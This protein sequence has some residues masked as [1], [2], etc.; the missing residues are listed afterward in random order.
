MALVVVDVGPR[1]ISHSIPSRKTMITAII[2]GTITRTELFRFIDRRSCSTRILAPGISSQACAYCSR[3][4][5]RPKQPARR[6]SSGAGHVGDT[7]ALWPSVQMRMKLFKCVL[8]HLV[9]I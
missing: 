5:E 1:R 3:V 7:R 4:M 9:L 8:E 6:S 2:V